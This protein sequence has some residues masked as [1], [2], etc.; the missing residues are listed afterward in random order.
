MMLEITKRVLTLEP[1]DVM[2]LERIITDEDH[3]GA[4]TFLRKNIYKKLL[5]SQENR[6]KSHLN[7]HSD[8]VTTFSKEKE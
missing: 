7:G 4:Y 8:P 6:L 3:E 2:E 5:L 1:E